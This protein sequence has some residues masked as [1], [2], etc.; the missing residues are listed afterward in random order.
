[1]FNSQRIHQLFQLKERLYKFLNS[2]ENVDI[3]IYKLLFKAV[4][5]IQKLNLEKEVR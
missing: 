4:G 3:F 1:M 5:R 2:L